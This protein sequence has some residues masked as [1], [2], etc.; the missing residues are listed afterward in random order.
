MEQGKEAFDH[1]ISRWARPHVLA[2]FRDRA[3]GVRQQPCI[4][5]HAKAG[6][7]EGEAADQDDPSH[8]QC[9]EERMAGR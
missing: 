1:G 6:T 5:V 3:G 8:D 2:C 9:G 4:V 7:D